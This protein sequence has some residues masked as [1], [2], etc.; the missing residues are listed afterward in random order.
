MS[1]RAGQLLVSGLRSAAVP[2]L[3]VGG[4][5]LLGRPRRTSWSTEDWILVGHATEQ[6]INCVVKFLSFR[7][8]P[9]LRKRGINRLATT[10]S[11]ITG[12]V[13]LGTPL[14]PLVGGTGA[15]AAEHL[16]AAPAGQAHQVAFLHPVGQH[17]VRERMA[18]QV[19]V[20]L[21]S[22][23]LPPALTTW[24]TPV[25]PSRPCLPSHSHGSPACGCSLERAGSGRWPAP[26]CGRTGRPAVGGPCPSPRRP[27]DRGRGRPRGGP[28]SSVRR[29]PVSRNSR[30]MAVSRRSS[31]SVP[32]QVASRARSSGFLEDR[33]AALRGRA[34]GGGWPSG[35]TASSPSA[36]SHR[37][38]CCRRA[39]AVGQGGRPL[40]AL[41]EVDQEGL[42]VARGGW[43]SR[44][45]SP[46]KAAS[47]SMA[48]P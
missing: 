12:A 17:R 46:T 14:G 37:K 11:R 2:R 41:A 36:T 8:R 21:E 44:S 18:E 19:G 20:E 22:G 42:D 35:L 39:V 28:A 34:A 48:A 26:S 5:E 1:H 10:H 29:I 7:G 6:S 27:C 40:P 38:N 43:R 16:P 33:R 23:L 45:T 47:R 30:R 31:K 25:S 4:V 3:S 9:R 15:V 24:A 32:S 13:Q